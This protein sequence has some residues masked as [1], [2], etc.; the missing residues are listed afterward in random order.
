[1]GEINYRARLDITEFR[2]TRDQLKKEFDEIMKL[3]KAAGGAGLDVKP[4]SEYQAGLLKVKQE[5]LEFAKAKASLAR[6]D[7][8]ALPSISA[9]NQAQLA[10]QQQLADARTEVQRLMQINQQ[11]R[12]ELE[13]GRIAAQNAKTATEQLKISEQEL[14]NELLA[15]K[16]SQHQFTE[17]VNKNKVAQT[18]LNKT[19]TEAAIKDKQAATALK[20]HN[21]EQKKIVAAAK[22]LKN[23]NT[24][25]S[26]SYKEAQQ[27]LT[28]L[29][30][31]I[32]GVQ[33]GF[34]NLTPA[35]KAKIREYNELNSKLKQFDETMG[36]HQRKVGDYRGA[37][38]GAGNDLASLATGYLSAGA[39][40]QYVLTSTMAFQGIKTPLTYILGSEGDAS[41]K[42]EELKKLAGE[43]G[44]E[45]FTLASSYKSFSAAARA[46]NF[47]LVQSEK[48]F[49][50]VTKASAV[51]GL[52][53]DQLEGAL[54]AVGQMISKG[55]VQAE[56]LRGQLAERLPGAFALSAKAMG[57]TEQELNKLL[58]T[59]QVLAADLLPKLALE[60]DKQYG[61]K[62]ADGIKGLN[63]EWQKLITLLQGTAGDSPGLS[64]AIFEPILKGAQDVVKFLNNSFRGSFTENFRYAFS[65]F[66]STRREL[67][68]VYDLRNSNKNNKSALQGAEKRD[69]SG[70]GLPELRNYYTQVEQTFRKAANDYETF[71]KG[72]ADGSIKESTDA[73]LAGYA[74]LVEGLAAQRNRVGAEIVKQKELIKKGS[75]DV[76]EAA[77][78][79]I[80][81]IRK[82]I[83]RLSKVDG[84]AIVGSDTYKQLQALKEQLKKSTKT[85]APGSSVK[86]EE[87]ALKRQ[88]SLQAEIDT[89]TKKG[90]AS[91]LDADQQ[92]VISVEEKY[93]KLREKA[94]AFNNAKDSKGQKVNLSGL[95]AAES[96]EKLEIKQKAESKVFAKSLDDQADMYVA[97]EEL[98][99]KIGEDKAEARY[100]DQLDTQK[101][102]LE[103][104]RDQ[105]DQ[106]KIGKG[107]GGAEDNEANKYALKELQDRI[108]KEELS[109]RKK[110]DNLMAEFMS[111]ADKRQAL[112]SQY[113]KD[114]LLLSDSADAKAARTEAYTRD[115]GELDDTNAQKLDAFKQLF[116]GID[117]LSDEN[118]RKVIANA[119][120][121]LLSSV[122]SKEL[123]AEVTKLIKDTESALASRMPERIINLANQIDQVAAAVSEVDEGFGKM[124]HTVGNVV[125]QVGNIKKGLADM[126]IAKGNGDVLGQLSSGLGIFGAAFTAFQGVSNLIGA[127]LKKGAEQRA[128][129]NEL[130]NK[131]TE[132][133]NKALERQI[134]L[135]NDAYGTERIT[136]YAAALAQ[137]NA[138]QK[139]YQDDLANRFTNIGDKTQDYWVSQ[140][141]SGSSIPGVSR[142]FLKKM[143]EQVGASKLPTDLKELQR[144]MDEGRLD[145][146]TEVIVKNLIDVAAAAKDLANNL[147]AETI[148]SSLD[149]I[150]DDFIGALTDGTQ[151][152]GKTFEDVIRTSIL[153]GFKGRLIQQQLQGFYDDFA[154]A[155]AEGGLSG[156]EIE[157]LRK[158]Y[159]TASEKAK[160]D[161]ADL[162]KATGISLSTTSASK[163][164]GGI[165]AVVTDKITQEQ[166]SEWI[167]LI[168]AQYDIA[169]QTAGNTLA[170]ATLL[171][172]GNKVRIDCFNIAKSHLDV[173]IQNE[174]NTFRTA[175]NTDGMSSKLDKII[176]NTSTQ[177]SRSLTG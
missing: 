53:S 45:Y 87:T 127:D 56:E 68:T 143:L 148:G 140:F 60:L 46:S 54:T 156:D 160:K 94:I 147:K 65:L 161:F 80:T 57:V 91:K 71:K 27:R 4:L 69:L 159:L 158:T 81:D 75:K 168:R 32:R 153:N 6:A 133:M 151:D 59:G 90:V 170:S 2:K 84:S 39:A 16:I 162:E 96:A 175:N 103:S 83:A 1:M 20:E 117:R 100:K 124:L 86:A 144:L 18:E 141:N 155:T 108:T 106:L 8:E 42:L 22:E 72:I 118:A 14:K 99:S 105:Y 76:K 11:Y 15:G 149:S 107:K 3:G 111:Y 142:D 63:A 67:Q 150:A 121:A 44:L 36:N 130:Q 52:S 174:R 134:A 74:R 109:E 77:L 135:I 131:Q 95:N 13:Q 102:Y 146:K 139:K 47:D 104:L 152:F 55:N 26:G 163:A 5:A 157:A 40:L 79:S 154:K 169:K 9:Y 64:S 176:E 10:F 132:A 73:N 164:N 101:T 122:M 129:A 17:A 41:T 30:N 119:K 34:E 62:A 116:A 43:L 50:S 138:D 61:D 98:K 48:I 33:G 23:A 110:Y 21:L 92:E 125:G 167:G 93:K 37:L 85:S 114:M 172:E 97:F 113:Q 112:E 7:K 171:S 115:L 70:S 126:K 66:N 19:L 177:S 28:E 165:T 89:L 78:T 31:R 35:M 82:E 58:E 24:A 120:A 49:T 173:A 88:R 137:A 123:K 136:K 51:L 38:Q 12:A 25:L 145:S 29:G 128:Y 166:G